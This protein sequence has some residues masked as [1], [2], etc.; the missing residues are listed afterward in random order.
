MVKLHGI[1]FPVVLEDGKPISPTLNSSIES[2]VKIALNWPTNNRFFLPSFGVDL[3][4]FI[5]EP[6]DNATHMFIRRKINTVISNY[7]RRASIE[8]IDFFPNEETL[9]ISMQ[10]R[11]NDTQEIILMNV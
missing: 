3:E 6:N 7:E 4:K 1:S 10:M 11:I 9:G 5:S 8:R 2:N